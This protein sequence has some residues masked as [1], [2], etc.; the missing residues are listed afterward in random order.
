MASFLPAKL[1]AHQKIIVSLA[2]T[3]PI[4]YLTPLQVINMLEKRVGEEAFRKLLERIV[5]SACESGSKGKFSVPSCMRRAAGKLCWSHMYR[6]MA[7]PALD[8]FAV[9]YIHR[10][11]KIS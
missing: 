11:L 8:E 1:E 9:I 4:R 6:G 2:C 3:L 10:Y 7:I 5:G